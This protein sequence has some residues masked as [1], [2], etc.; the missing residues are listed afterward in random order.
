M[1]SQNQLAKV[2]T[3]I[4]DHYTPIVQRRCVAHRIERTS[5]EFVEFMESVDGV[6]F[7]FIVEPKPGMVLN[8]MQDLCLA[9]EHFTCWEDPGFALE[10]Y[11]WRLGDGDD[12]QAAYMQGGR[13]CIWA[14]GWK[15]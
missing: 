11:R 9:L 1:L 15:E 7:A 8:D 14:R 4:R 6:R 2:A 12:T 5:V 13:V 3:Q 10:G